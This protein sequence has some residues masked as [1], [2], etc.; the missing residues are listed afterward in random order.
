M[1]T[2]KLLAFYSLSGSIPRLCWLHYGGHTGAPLFSL[3]GVLGF[4]PLSLPYLLAI[5]GIVAA[6]FFSAEMA[7]RWF[8][9]QVKNN[10]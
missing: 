9:R 3:A 10:G 4:V 5:F 8:Y 2:G 6:Y 7:K 1:D